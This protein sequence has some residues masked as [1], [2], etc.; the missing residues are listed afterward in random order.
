RRAGRDRPARA[1]AGVRRDAPAGPRRRGGALMP[2]RRHGVPTNAELAEAVREFLEREVAPGAEGRL[3]FMTRVAITVM[4]MLGGEDALGPE[5]AR[6]HAAALAG[7]GIADDVELCRA[8]RDGLLDDR[9]DEVVA[10]TREH[11]IARLRIANPRYLR[12][13]DQ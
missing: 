3:R 5:C 7:L 8:I 2:E 9:M 12:G 11:A 6:A 13:E 10:I 1:G 4:A